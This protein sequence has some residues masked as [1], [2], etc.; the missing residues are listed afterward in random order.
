MKKEISRAIS[1]ISILAIL[2]ISMAVVG[3]AGTS[4]PINIISKPVTRAAIEPVKEAAQEPLR[5]ETIADTAAETSVLQSAPLIVLKTNAKTEIPAEQKIDPNTEIVKR[6]DKDKNTDTNTRVIAAS[7]KMEINHDAVARETKALRYAGDFWRVWDESSTLLHIH[8]KTVS[9]DTTAGG[10][11]TISVT[12]TDSDDLVTR[13]ALG[14][15]PYGPTDFD[16]RDCDPPSHSCTIEFEKSEPEPGVYGYAL[17][18]KNERNHIANDAITVTVTERATTSYFNFRTAAMDGEDYG[19]GVIDYVDSEISVW[20]EGIPDLTISGTPFATFG[21]P[22][23][24]LWAVEYVADGYITDTDF[25]YFDSRLPSCS[26]SGC[27]FTADVDGVT[28]TTGCDLVV[29]DS[30]YFCK[31]TNDEGYSVSFDYRAVG[32]PVGPNTIQRHNLIYPASAPIVDFGTLDAVFIEGGYL[33]IPLDDY[34]YDADTDP[35]DLTWTV[36]RNEDVQVEIDPATHEATVTQATPDWIGSEIIEFSVTDPEMNTGADVVTVRVLQDDNDPPVILSKSP[37]ADTVNVGYGSSRLFSIDAMDPDYDYITITWRK[38]GTV[39]ATDTFSYNYVDTDGIPHPLTVI[40][41]DGTEEASEAWDIDL[42]EPIGAVEGTVTDQDTS[43]PIEGVLVQLFEPGSTTLVDDTNTDSSGHYSLT[44]QDGTYDIKFT[45]EGYYEEDIPDVA[46]YA[47]ETTTQDAELQA[48]PAP[49]GTLQGIVRDAS[50]S[51]PLGGVLVEALIGTTVINSTSTN[52]AGNYMMDLHEGTYK[53]RFSKMGY[54]TLEITGVAITTGA[55]TT[56]NVDL[57]ETTVTEGTISGTVTQEGTGTPLSGVLVAVMDGMT[58]I[59]SMTTPVGGTYSMTVT[60]DTYD[61]R[62]SKAGYKTETVTGVSVPAG[63]TTTLNFAMMKW[64]DATYGVKYPITIDADSRL[65]ADTQFPLKIVLNSSNIDYSDFQADGGDVRFVDGTDTTELPYFIEVWNSSGTSIAYASVTVS[66]TSSGMIY[67]YGDAT[68]VEAT[69]SDFVNTF[70]ASLRAFY[71]FNDFA[72]D[73]SAN[74]LDGVVNGASH[75][76]DYSEITD[77]VYGHYSFDGVSN[78]IN[79]GDPSLL[80]FSGGQNFA[81]SAWFKPVTSIGSHVLYSRRAGTNDYAMNLGYSSGEIRGQIWE[82]AGSKNCDN[83]Y[84]L[85]LVDGFWHHVFWTCDFTGANQ[86]Y[87]YVDGDLK[88]AVPCATDPDT[89]G[90][91][92]TVAIGRLGNYDGYY[93]DGLIDEVRIYGT[94]LGLDYAKL[95]SAQTGYAVGVPV[96]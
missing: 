33:T 8:E 12:A 57:E 1:A 40:V 91:T 16:A 4:A 86:C 42:V 32:D 37:D 47:G 35:S 44:V 19:L 64:W 24:E 15:A 48:V 22:S 6:Y 90:G 82:S 71:S 76:V 80:K 70:G 17:K 83:S 10:T 36:E 96:T 51:S 61:V 34:V 77:K 88:N 74:S 27:E 9:G 7:A 89:S 62:F 31:L 65:S 39:V 81:V 26:G 41:S 20:R 60:A 30:H 2:I 38:G 78:W 29:S 85:D 3:A 50:T 92:G 63:V 67:V 84:T 14:V 11:F 23:D 68:A 43:A 49:I 95:L 56:R 54:Q 59:D 66:P 45:K 94:S 18:A 73:L 13:I 53:V 69:S 55:T 93:W 46:I 28:Y 79:L 75:Q 58:V 87:I 52:A 25:F 5:T 21:M 72:Q